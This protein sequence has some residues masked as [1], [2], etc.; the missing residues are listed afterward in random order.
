MRNLQWGPKGH[1]GSQVS[2]KGRVVCGGKNHHE[3]E[4]RDKAKKYF[5]G[6]PKITN[7]ENRRKVVPGMTMTKVRR[8]R[9]CCSK[10]E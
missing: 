3:R 2:S 1:G 7:Q 10:N 4:I 5:E 8:R 6:E 9:D